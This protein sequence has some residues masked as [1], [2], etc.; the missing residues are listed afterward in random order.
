M[1]VAVGNGNELNMSCSIAKAVT[2]IS[3]FFM[4]DWAK[5]IMK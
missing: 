5:K 4:N 3:I 2:F 1:L